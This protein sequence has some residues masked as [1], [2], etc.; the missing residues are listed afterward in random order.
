[1]KKCIKI[2]IKLIQI[3]FSKTLGCAGKCE[4]IGTMTP[5]LLFEIEL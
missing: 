2:L 5:F 1:M 3:N 4:S